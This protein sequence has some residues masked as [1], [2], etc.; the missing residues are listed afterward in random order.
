MCKKR[1]SEKVFEGRIRH[2][3]ILKSLQGHNVLKEN[4]EGFEGKLGEM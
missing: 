3:D 4:I 1:Q 2:M